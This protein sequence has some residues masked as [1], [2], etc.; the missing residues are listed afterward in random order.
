MSVVQAGH[1]EHYIRKI[2]ETSEGYE[3]EIINLEGSLSILDENNSVDKHR[4]GDYIDWDCRK[5]Q[6]LQIERTPRDNINEIEN[7]DPII[8]SIELAGALGKCETKLDIRYNSDNLK[9][10]IDELFDIA[11]LLIGNEGNIYLDGKRAL[12]KTLTVKEKNYKIIKVL[13]Y[14]EFNDEQTR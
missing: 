7:K 6:Y 11:N 10:S 2:S 9:N 4:L 1:S 13:H 12:L 8:I 14:S 3:S 5:I